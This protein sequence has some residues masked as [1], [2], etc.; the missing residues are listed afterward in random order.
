MLKKE[1]GEKEEME[2]KEEVEE[3]PREETQPAATGK[4]GL[5]TTEKR[6]EQG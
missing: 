2:G 3:K 6:F 4:L 5:F 1:M